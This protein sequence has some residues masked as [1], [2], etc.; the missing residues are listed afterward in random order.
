[1]FMRILPLAVVLTAAS[2]ATP[3][4]AQTTGTGTGTG[5]QGTTATGQT[6]TMT[7]SG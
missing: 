5:Q 1:M 4:A 2:I 7:V 6:G 3:A